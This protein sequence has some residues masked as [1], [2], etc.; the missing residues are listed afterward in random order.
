MDYADLQPTAKGRKTAEWIYE[1]PI[2]NEKEKRKKERRKE[3]NLPAWV[4]KVKATERS[5]SF[6]S[7]FHKELYVYQPISKLTIL[8]III[9]LFNTL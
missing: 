9:Y 1:E 5:F 2:K 4:A 3:S 8:F 7:C 6:S